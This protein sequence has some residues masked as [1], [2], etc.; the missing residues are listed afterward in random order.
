MLLKCFGAYARTKNLQSKRNV[1]GENEITDSVGCEAIMKILV[2]AYPKDLEELTFQEIKQ[3][4]RNNLRPKKMLVITERT[5]FLSKKQNSYKSARS[6]LHRLKE[7]S[8]FCEF[9]K[10]GIEN[11]TI[12]EELIW[13]HFIEGLHDVNQ[14]NKILER[15]QG[16]NITMETCIEFKQQLEMISDSVKL[17]SITL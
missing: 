13:L 6:Y 9:E 15:L 17:H 11:I 10:L 7:A 4:I 1:G 8:R 14:K 12:E 3:I 5:K 2:M 16:N